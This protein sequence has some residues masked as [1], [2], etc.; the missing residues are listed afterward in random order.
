[1]K[2]VLQSLALY[3]SPGQRATCRTMVTIRVTFQPIMVRKFGFIE[4]LNRVTRTLTRRNVRKQV[5]LAYPGNVEAVE[6]SK[7][8]NVGIRGPLRTKFGRITYMLYCV[9]KKKSYEISKV[10]PISS[11]KRY[12]QEQKHESGS[13]VINIVFTYMVYF[14]YYVCANIKFNKSQKQYYRIADQQTY[15]LLF[16]LHL[17]VFSIFLLSDIL[18]TS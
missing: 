5:S 6:V 10:P 7:D 13:Q 18:C 8:A 16:L 9:Q 11:R 14:R 12:K 15:F 1:M 3:F 2:S 17:L 4:M